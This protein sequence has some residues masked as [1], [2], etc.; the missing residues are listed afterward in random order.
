[1]VFLFAVTAVCMVIFAVLY[2]YYKNKWGNKALI[3]KALATS[4]A[5]IIAAVRVV[6]T[7]EL[8]GTLILA[9]LIM[10]MTADVALEIDFIKGIMLFG[11]AHICFAAAYIQR[12]PANRVTCICLALLYAATVF[13]FGKD[14]KR[15]GDLKIPAFVYMLLLVFMVSMAFTVYRA[16]KGGQ[17]L[18]LLSGA[19][20]FFVSDC[21]IGF[22][23]LRNQ[24]SLALGAAILVLYYSAVYMIGVSA[25]WQM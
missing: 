10:C 8:Y 14:L 4:M 11:A 22:R 15:L 6:K 9:G 13:L 16:D 24:K 19:L 20:C 7:K 3:W 1:M 18:V 17:A 21:I 2:G 5:V 25:F 23:T 12:T